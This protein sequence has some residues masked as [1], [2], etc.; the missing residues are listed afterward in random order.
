MSMIS[1]VGTKTPVVLPAT[2]RTTSI[3]DLVNGTNYQFR[4]VAVNAAGAGLSATVSATPTNPDALTTVQFTKVGT[5]PVT[6]QYSYTIRDANGKAQTR[7]LTVDI[8]SLDRS[9]A[10]RVPDFDR[11]EGTVRVSIA[12]RNLPRGM[13]KTQSFTVAKK[14]NY[15]MRIAYQTNVSDPWMATSIQLK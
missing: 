3:G 12:V 7:F 9:G 15:S 6:V 2:A 11:I 1:P 4:I 10:I 5:L 14:T 8:G 13:T